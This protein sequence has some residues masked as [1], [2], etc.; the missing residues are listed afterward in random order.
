MTRR[1][2]LAAVPLLLLVEAAPAAN[3]SR[4]PV[5]LTSTSERA[6]PMAPRAK[7]KAKP[8]RAA[9]PI[10]P[11]QEIRKRMVSGAKVSGKELPHPRRL[12][13]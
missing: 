1:L 12:R 4:V 6:A 3:F 8:A 13:R 10:D 2:L 11:M 9:K 7:S 5:S